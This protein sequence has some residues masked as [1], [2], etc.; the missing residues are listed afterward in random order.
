MKDWLVV[1]DLDGTLA[2]TAGDLMF[3]LNHVLALDGIPPLPVDQA[4]LL[5][6]AG[7]RALIERGYA[8][9][10]HSLDKAKL[11]HLFR[12]FLEIYEANI[13][14]HTRL[15]P[16]VLP[17][18]DRLEQRGARFAVCTNK[19]EQASLKLL[20]ELGVAARFAAICGQNSF[21]FCK[22]DARA[23][24]STIAKAGGRADQAIMVG[25]SI[26]DIATARNAGIPVVA[27]DFGYTDKPVATLG[28]DRIISHYDE[29]DAALDALAARSPA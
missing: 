6:G 27:V 13:A 4:R 2:D 18:L 17:A 15:F 24:L 7:G 19:M 21:A 8:S 25:D 26:T 3:A 22:P 5:L 29:I 11:E 12:I 10:G 23:L 16:G 28:P 14:V 1:F 20:D 9:A